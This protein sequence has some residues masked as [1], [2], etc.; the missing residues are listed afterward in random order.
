MAIPIIIPRL[1]WNMEEGVFLGWLIKHGEP[2]RA[3]EMLFRLESEKAA[4]DIECHDAGILRIAPNG[5]EEGDTVPVGCVIGYLVQADE[6]FQIADFELQLEKQPI[7]ESRPAISSKSAVARL[8]S[9]ISSP[10]ARRVAREMGVDWT[11][12]QGSGRNG[13]IR[14]KDVR[15]A[16]QTRG[17]GKIV[18]L[19]FMRRAGIERLVMS[20][21]STVPVTLTITA[22]VTDLLKLRQEFKQTGDPPP[23]LTDIFVKLAALALQQHPLLSARWAQ[24]HLVVPDA[25]HIGIAVDTDAGLVVPVVHDAALSS[26]QQIAARSRE[27]IARARAG[28]LTTNDLHGGV[29]TITNLGMF[30]IDAFT[31]IINYPECAVLG[32]GCI[33]PVL[34]LV[35]DKP[36]AREQLTLSLTFDHRIVDGAP[37][38]RFL[39]TLTNGI[40]NPGMVSGEW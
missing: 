36:V 13:R 2:V 1:G 22:D 17:T 7:T 27:L 6:E 4:E 18:P 9:A 24:D 15:A 25:I 3:G 12:V 38:A 35:D 40:E 26:L 21:Q 8:Q 16:A 11:M 5:P 20:V 29:F 28:K 14:E 34:V 33:R 30:G 23:S 10:R 37:A 19:S 39:Q 31:P 32:I